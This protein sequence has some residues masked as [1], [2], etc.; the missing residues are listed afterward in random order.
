MLVLDALTVRFYE[1]PVQ[2]LKLFLRYFAMTLDAELSA[3]ISTLWN[4]EYLIVNRH[5]SIIESS[6]NSSYLPMPME[7]W[8]MKQLKHLQS[9]LPD[10][11]EE[12]LLPNLLALLDV[13]ARSCTKRILER[14]PNL[15]RLG[16]RIEL[17]PDNVEPTLSCFDHISYLD[18]LE[19]LKYVVVNPIFTIAWPTPLPIFP[20]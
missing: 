7:I 18:E 8:D 9:D 6:G 5:M 15:K 10:P 3:S 11:N 16:I 20:V 12:S 13:G 4:L 14:T 19:A 17:S 1:F 2:V